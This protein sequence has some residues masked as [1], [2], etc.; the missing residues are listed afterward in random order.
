M[1]FDWI[2]IRGSGLVAY[3]LLAASTIWGLLIT[4][5]VLGPAV[6][7]KGITWFH[8]ALGIAGVLA[9]IV[10]IVALSLHDYLRF[11]WA[12]IL[13]P[14]RSD[15]NPNAV[16]FGIVAFYGATIIAV[17]FYV[18][19]WIGQQAWRAIHF[20]SLGAF[21]SA[22]IHGITAGTDSAL[23]LVS[24]LYAATGAV[25]VMLVIVRVSQEMAGQKRPRRVVERPAPSPSEPVR[26]G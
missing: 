19:R 26:P 17:S 9:T 25:V 13:I 12:E 23:P 5:K 3:A 20:G 1:S 22:L 18:K 7:A 11:S 2:L 10:H 24:A 8:E 15:W 6:K 14:G 21:A 16:A 4:T